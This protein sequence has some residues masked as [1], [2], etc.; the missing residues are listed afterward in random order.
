GERCPG[1][2]FIRRASLDITGTLPTPEQVKA[3]VASNDPNKRDKLIDALLESPEYSYYFAN[4]WADILRVKRGNQPNRAYGTFAF[5]TWIREAI[6]QDRP[7]DEFTREIIGAIGDETKCPPTVWY[8]D[9]QTADQFADN[10]AQVFL[11]VRMQ[12]A[13]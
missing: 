13:Q 11:G 10:L 8:K 7:Y 9:L 5:H 1:E 4:K 2:P 3:F 6:A 12:C